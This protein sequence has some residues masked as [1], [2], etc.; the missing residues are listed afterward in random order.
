MTK[1]F[2]SLAKSVTN[3]LFPSNAEHKLLNMCKV[4]VTNSVK[5]VTYFIACFIVC[6]N[7]NL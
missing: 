2:G 4:L 7:V 3:M 1:P 6:G 5:N